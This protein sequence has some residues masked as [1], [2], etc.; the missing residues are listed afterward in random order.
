MYLCVPLQSSKELLWTCSSTLVPRTAWLNAAD[1]ISQKTTIIEIIFESIKE[2]D[3]KVETKQNNTSEPTWLK[4]QKVT[5]QIQ[6]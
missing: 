1:R 3:Q 4:R 6:R 5:L 2:E